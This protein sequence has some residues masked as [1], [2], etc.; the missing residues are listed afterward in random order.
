MVAHEKNVPGILPPPLFPKKRKDRL[1]SIKTQKQYLSAVLFFLF[2]C[3]ALL[4][5]VPLTWS[6]L[7]KKEHSFLLNL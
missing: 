2:I 3:A 5:A 1:E 6:C 7:T 4:R